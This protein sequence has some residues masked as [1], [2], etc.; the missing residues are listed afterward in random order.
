M[1]K[2]PFLLSILPIIALPQFTVHAEEAAAVDRVRS[3]ENAQLDGAIDL[4]IQTH[5]AIAAAKANAR[6]A[7]I[8]VSASRWQRFPSLSV[9]GMLLDQSNNHLQAQVVVDQPIWTG[10]RISGSISRAHSRENAALAACDEAVLNIAIATAQAYFDAHRWRQRVVILTLGLE[11][12]NRLLATME[13]RYAQD[14]SPLSDLE[15]ARSR[16]RQVEQQLI[17]AQASEGAAANRLRDL[18]GDPFFNLGPLPAL[19]ST[20][21]KLDEGDIAARTLAYSPMLRRLRFEA[22]SSAADARIA[23]AATLPQLSGQYSYSDTFGHRFGI[24][25]KSQSDGGLSRFVAADAASQRAEASELQIAAGERQ[26]RDQVIT[27]LRSYE[28]GSTR[29]EG[30]IA[31]SGSAQRVMESYMRQFASGRRTW[32]DVM[33]AQR[34]ATSAEIDAFDARIEAQGALTALLLLSG[35]WLADRPEGRP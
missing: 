1:K 24:V 4:A 20:W 13:R 33:N 3:N 21:P 16:T 15:L 22:D 5:P 17:Q 14:V 27:L 34:E 25:L 9:E 12:H 28:A 2:F 11:Q 32:L 10:G 29:L 30:S 18:V 26:L 7:G 23:R 19:P 6:A 8:E 35:Q 31:A